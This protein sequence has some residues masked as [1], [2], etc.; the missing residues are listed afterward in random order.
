VEL[1]VAKGE[2]RRKKM[3]G[4]LGEEME[5]NEASGMSWWP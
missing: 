2:Q 5:K 1:A 3:G 4:K